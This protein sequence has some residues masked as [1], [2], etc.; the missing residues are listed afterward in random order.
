[1]SGSLIK[2]DEEIVTTAVASVTLTGIDSTYD[3]YMLK[4]N[5]V[6]ADTD[7]V[8]LR[9]RLTVSGTPDTS[10]NYDGAGK[11]LRANTT[12]NNSSYTNLNQFN[13]GNTGTGTGEQFN[14]VHYLFN[15]NNAS[16]YSFITTETSFLEHSPALQGRQGGEVLTV[17]QATDGV[18]LFYSSGNITE[19]TFT[20]YG[21]KK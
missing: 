3:V 10:A 12:F 6:V 8:G 7:A 17:A 13:I 11:V 18:H 4:Y 9:I 20:L 5:N 1:M 19:G 14:G 2:I 15:F 21:L 16:E